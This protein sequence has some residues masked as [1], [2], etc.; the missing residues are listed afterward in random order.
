MLAPRKKLYKK[1][2]KEDKIIT[3]INKVTV[4]FQNEWQKL[5]SG[6][7]V[8]LLIIFVFTWVQKSSLEREANATSELYVYEDRY[9]NEI[10]DD[11]LIAGLNTIIERYK[12]TDAGNRAAFL[13]ANTFF[14]LGNYEQAEMQ[15]NTFL[16]EHDGDDFMK[17]SALNGIAATFEQREMYNQSAEKYNEAANRYPNTFLVPE[18]LLGAARSYEKLGQLEEART[19]C[20]RILSDFPD[21]PQAE[22]AEVIKAR[23]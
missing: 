2:L 20:E 23:L 3:T 21:T 5:L 4:F 9:M 7:V 8:V 18:S 22:E 12:D 15:F 17:C 16:N 6:A 11:Q 1:Q 13:L 19:R 10:Y 14:H